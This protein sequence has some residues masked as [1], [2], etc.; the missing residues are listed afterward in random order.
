MPC[1]PSPQGSPPLE[2]HPGRRGDPSEACKLLSA[3]T[4]T[5]KQ[6]ILELLYTE[7]IIMTQSIK[8]MLK[9]LIHKFYL[10]V[11]HQ[12]HNSVLRACLDLDYMG[13]STGISCETVW[14]T[15][16]QLMT[17]LSLFS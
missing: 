8:N 16:K 17:F 4:D 15:S 3:A 11:P 7:D 10:L 5:N 13:L 12:L 6:K 14:E 2:T 9:A 1:H